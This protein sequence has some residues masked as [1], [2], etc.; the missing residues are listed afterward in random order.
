MLLC[1]VTITTATSLKGSI[2][3]ELDYS[4]EVSAIIIVGSMV[5]PT[6]MVLKRGPIVLYLDQQV[7]GR[8]SHWAHFE[9][10]KPQSPP[11]SDT[12]PPIRP[13]LLIVLPA[14]SLWGTIFIHITTPTSVVC[15]D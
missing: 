14:V 10:L 3:L 4:L 5:V 15:A 13:C 1:G 11:P 8:E 6:D 2:E 12:L 9:H 7:A